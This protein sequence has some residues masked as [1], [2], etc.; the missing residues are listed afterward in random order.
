MFVP[1]PVTS[2]HSGFNL[3]TKDNITTW[4]LNEFYS[5]WYWPS[6]NQETS[7]TRFC[8]TIPTLVLLF[9]HS[10]THLVIPKPSGF[11]GRKRWP[12]QSSYVLVNVF[13]IYLLRQN[14]KMIYFSLILNHD[15][16]Q[17]PGG[18]GRA[19]W[20]NNFNNILSYSSHR[21]V[22]KV[23]NILDIDIPI[24]IIKIIFGYYYYLFIYII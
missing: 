12:P 23:L 20:L 4:Y 16:Y 14:Y 5:S 2:V 24:K 10:K 1:V 8:H 17:E 22:H 18:E 21:I 11:E 3:E 19:P 9:I 13:S 7:P 15:N 6:S